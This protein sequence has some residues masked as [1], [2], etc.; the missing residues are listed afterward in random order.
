MTDILSFMSMASSVLADAKC[1]L[2]CLSAC[3]FYLTVDTLNVSFVSPGCQ[4]ESKLQESQSVPL[5]FEVMPW[6]LGLRSS[7]R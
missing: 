5:F 4:Q 2:H 7:E 3:V 6:K 1:K